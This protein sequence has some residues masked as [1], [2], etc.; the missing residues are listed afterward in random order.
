MLAL[1]RVEARRLLLHPLTLFGTAI[2]ALNGVRAVVEDGGP[3]EAFETI[4]AMLGFYP[5]VLMILVGGLVATRDLRA[6]SREMLG[7][8][9]G[10]LQERTSAFLLAALVPAAVGLLGV[11]ALHGFFL[12]DERYVAAP[13]VG[14]ILQG[15]ALMLGGTALGLMVST[16]APSRSTAVLT[17]VVMVAG[18]MW[19]NSQEALQLF[20]PVMLWAAWGATGSTWVGTID[21]LNRFDGYEVAHEFK[22]LGWRV[23]LLNARRL[24]HLQLGPGLLLHGH[25]HRVRAVLGRDPGVGAAYGGAG[26]VL[27]GPPRLPAREGGRGRLRLHRRAAG[28]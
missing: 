15:P 12:L 16:W 2:F 11:L 13:G 26:G 7:P 14:N 28:R 21:G 8:V 4:D 23:M 25:A 3:R 9:P 18:T 17:M 1:A 10:R 22:D 19:L 27:H 5:G 20:G 24:D 6:G